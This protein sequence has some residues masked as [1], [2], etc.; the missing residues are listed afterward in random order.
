MVIFNTTYPANPGVARLRSF[1]DSNDNPCWVKVGGVVQ[2]A[3]K[4]ANVGSHEAGHTLGLNH[5][6][7]AS[8]EYYPGHS[9]YRVIM[10]TVTNGYSQFSKGEYS[11]ANNREDDL[12]VLSGTSN[13]V[14]YRTDDHGNNITNSTSLL[15]ETNGDVLEDGNFGLIEKTSD[16]DLFKMEV[17]AGEIN[18]EVRPANKYNFSQNLD[19]K[20]RLLDASGTEITNADANGFDASTLNATVAEGVYYLEINGVGLGD[21]LAEGYTDYGSLGQ[22][23][24]SGQVPPASLSVDDIDNKTSLQI[25]PNPTTG[26]INVKHNFIQANYK[27]ITI[28]G[29]IVTNGVFSSGHEKLDVSSLAKGIYILKINTDN[30]SFTSKLVIK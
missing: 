13:G 30:K 10:G 27:I 23:F 12:Q 24:I 4:A 6:G 25:F 8:V 5:D 16:I 26:E 21:P 22:Y 7:N 9:F 14:G 20:A 15:I 28:H 17:I 3:V 18:L 19:L 29:A 2:S 11:G 1:S